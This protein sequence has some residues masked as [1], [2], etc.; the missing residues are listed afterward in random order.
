MPMPA[1]SAQ[2]IAVLLTLVAGM[3]AVSAAGRKA[4]RAPVD[5]AAQERS[6]PGPA[7]TLKAF[8]SLLEAGKFDEARVLC[9]GQALRMYDFLAMTQARLT[10]FIDTARSED[11]NLEEKRAGDWAYIK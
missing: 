10:P 8:D 9:T 7:A 2:K 6:K 4:A 11:K 5:S 3:G 1:L